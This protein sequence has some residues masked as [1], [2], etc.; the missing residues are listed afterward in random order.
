MMGLLTHNV[1]LCTRQS[2]CL[3]TNIVMGGRRKCRISRRQSNLASSTFSNHFFGYRV[4]TVPYILWSIKASIARWGNFFQSARS[5]S[6]NFIVAT[7]PTTKFSTRTSFGREGVVIILMN[8]SRFVGTLFVPLLGGI[9]LGHCTGC[10][11]SSS[12]M[13]SSTLMGDSFVSS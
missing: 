1:S 13:S 8:S 5:Q 2:N 11:G 6:S 10:T 4:V 12:G 3:M 7:R 9:Y